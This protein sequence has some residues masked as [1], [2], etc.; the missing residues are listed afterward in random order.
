[1]YVAGGHTVGELITELVEGRSL[2]VFLD[3]KG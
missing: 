2:R 3:A 1:M